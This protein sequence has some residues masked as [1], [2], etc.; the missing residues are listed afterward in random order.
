M[1]GDEVSVENLLKG[2]IIAS[3]NDACVA[4]AEGIAGTEEEFSILMT[5][6]AKELGMDNTIFSNSSGINHPGTHGST[7]GGNPLAMSVGNAVLDQIFKKGF[8]RNVQ[9]VSKYFHL[10][11]KKIQ[12]KY[13]NIIK[14]IRGVGLL[15]GIQ[16]FKDQTKFIQKLMDKK[17]LTIK[18]AENVIRVLPPLTIKKKEID[19]AIKIINQVCREFKN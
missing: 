19:L 12:K 17:L 11:L 1:V 7:F 5:A 2:I 14:E 16:L 6:K 3:G 13:P 9:T 15:I 10:E 8:L 18:A 4:L